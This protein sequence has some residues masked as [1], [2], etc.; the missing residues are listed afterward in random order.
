M[1]IH[2]KIYA[3]RINEIIVFENTQNV[4]QIYLIDNFFGL[5]C[6]L[7]QNQLLIDFNIIFTRKWSF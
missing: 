1:N 4:L 6:Q 2:K 3:K 5:I 7:Y